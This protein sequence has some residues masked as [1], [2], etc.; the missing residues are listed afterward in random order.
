[1]NLPTSRGSATANPN[2]PPLRPGKSAR[3]APLPS[4][5]IGR[6]Q[7]LHRAHLWLLEARKAAFKFNGIAEK[8]GSTVRNVDRF[9]LQEKP[10][11]G[12]TDGSD[13]KLYLLK[14]LSRDTS[15]AVI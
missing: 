7:L 15:K 3:V 9:G 10:S 11:K 12:R 4:E 2:L 5:A 13:Y 14:Q 6:L 1:M 8:S